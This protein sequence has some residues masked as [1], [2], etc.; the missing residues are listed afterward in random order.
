MNEC[1]SP[2]W[3][4]LAVIQHV[5]TQVLTGVLVGHSFF[6]AL[7]HFWISQLCFLATLMQ[8]TSATERENREKE[9]LEV[10]LD[11]F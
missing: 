3:V 8:I 6:A 9:G 5:H 10:G 1:T 11:V 7:M 2:C 4:V